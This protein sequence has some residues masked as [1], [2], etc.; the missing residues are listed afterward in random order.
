MAKVSPDILARKLV[1]AASVPLK[2][3]WPDYQKYAEPEFRR[4]ARAIGKIENE[5]VGG[6]LSSAAARR[7][8]GVREKI[9]RARLLAR[10]KAPQADVRRAL[11]AAA[12]VTHQ[13]LLRI[14]K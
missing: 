12:V 1:D 2:E 7:R 8:V 5:R 9:I 3:R 14:L 13:A 10:G 6:R 11:R 4:L